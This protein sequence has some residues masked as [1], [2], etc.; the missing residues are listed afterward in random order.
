ME[1]SQDNMK[2][3]HPEQIPATNEIA[4]V[5]DKKLISDVTSS[6]KSDDSYA[7]ESR[8]SCDLM[9]VLC[10]LRIWRFIC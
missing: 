8:V 6:S 5:R 1:K 4:A 7:E 10:I 3:E 9:T 2:K